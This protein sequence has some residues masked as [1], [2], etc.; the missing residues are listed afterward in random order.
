MVAEQEV[1]A[2]TVR[3]RVTEVADPPEP[4]HVTDC[5]YVPAVFMGPVLDPGLDVP[6]R[7]P[8]QKPEPE[9][10]SAL[11]ELNDMEEDCPTV[12]EEGLNALRV[13]VGAEVHADRVHVAEAPFVPHPGLVAPHV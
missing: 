1:G 7:S 6:P 10:E 12:M 9:Q 2:P 3:D 11:V 13:T 4:E 8:F 5:V